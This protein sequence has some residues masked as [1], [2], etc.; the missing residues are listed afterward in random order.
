MN[1]I[2]ER[3][4]HFTNT[5]H[6]NKHTDFLSSPDLKNALHNI[7]KDFV[8]VSIDNTTSNITLVCKRFY[9]TAISIELGLKLDSHLQKKLLL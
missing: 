9:A 2:D 8:A 7:H 6:T 4:S 5:L 1:K 3:I